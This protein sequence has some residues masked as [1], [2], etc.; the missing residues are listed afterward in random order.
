M[1]LEKILEPFSGEV[2]QRSGNKK[3]KHKNKSQSEAGFKK[4]VR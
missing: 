2:I 1:I 4:V 3:D